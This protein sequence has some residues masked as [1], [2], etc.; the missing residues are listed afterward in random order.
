MSNKEPDDAIMQALTGNE[1]LTYG[2]LISAAQAIHPFSKQTITVHLQDLVK[3]GYLS[4]KHVK[5]KQ[6]IRYSLKIPNTVMHKDMVQLLEDEVKFAKNSHKELIKFQKSY[7]K[8]FHRGAKLG[9]ASVEERLIIFSKTS[10]LISYV[11]DRSKWF[12]LYKS[13][14]L[15]PS[16]MKKLLE[17]LEKQYSKTVSDVLNLIYQ[18]DQI[19]YRQL[20]LNIIEKLNRAS[21][22]KIKPKI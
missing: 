19:M 13:E 9:K 14:P 3:R 12:I 21:S 11:V 2:N 8:R 6:F 17:D 10:S 1:Y 20:I 5:G 22:F 16:K 18:T 15:I 7:K 4:K